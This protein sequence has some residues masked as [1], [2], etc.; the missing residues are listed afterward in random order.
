MFLTKNSL[1]NWHS[2][3]KKNKKI[4]STF[5]I[6][7]Q[8]SKYDFGAF[9]WTVH[10]SA[11]FFN[12]FSF[13]H[14]DSWAKFLLLGPTIFE[15][16]QPNWYYCR[17][18]CRCLK[19]RSLFR[20]LGIYNFEN[21]LHLVWKRPSIAILLSSSTMWPAVI[22]LKVLERKNLL[23]KDTDVCNKV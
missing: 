11:E 7:D 21:R 4:L 1:L 20:E 12:F 16:P 9:E 13:E 8:L 18:C 2:Y 22:C 6:K 17:S 19:V 23:F 5:D 14:V 10:S 3:M 15:I